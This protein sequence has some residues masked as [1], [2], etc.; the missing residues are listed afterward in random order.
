MSGLRSALD[1]WLDEDIESR[2]VDLLADDLVELEKISG[3]LEATR[4]RRLEVF[5][6][7]TGHHSQGYPSSTAFLMA[8]CRMGAGRAMREVARAHT[9]DTAAHV[10]ESWIQGR[11][12]TDQTYELFRVSTLVPDRFAAD[13]PA[14]VEIVQDL[15]VGATRRALDYWRST[16]D[17]PG[18]LD[19]ATGL[20]DRR[21][22]SLSAGLGGT[23]RLDGDLT[24]VAKETLRTALDALMA[25]PGPQENR[26]PRQRRHDAL[27]DLARFYLDHHHTPQVGGDKPHVNILCDLAA[28]AGIAGGTHETETGQVLTVDQIRALACD[29]TVSRIVL[30]PGSEIID[31]GRRTRTIPA[32]LRRALTARD[33]HCTWNRCD[34]PARWCDAHHIQHWADG[35]KTSLENLQL[36]CRYHHTLTHRMERPPTTE[37]DHPARAGVRQTCRR[38]RWSPDGSGRIRRSHPGRT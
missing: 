22:V 38:S 19:E 35:G 9:L 25:P 12:G 6:R 34:R 1:E 13:Q 18:V 17:G 3:L 31:V 15:S 20:A 26:T 11:I 32:A 33:R 4:L 37:P 16:V 10:L 30:G 21:G 36:L 28:L 27:E 24:A 14:L 2:P 23:G 5:D 29:S 7:K 8:K